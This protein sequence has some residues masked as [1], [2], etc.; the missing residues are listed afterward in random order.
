MKHV[1]EV[2]AD[3]LELFAR[4][5]DPELM[6]NLRTIA[7]DSYA[8]MPYGDAITVLQRSGKKFEFPVEYGV[9]LQTEHER[10]LTEEYCRKPVM[11]HDYPR[12]IK[13]FY[14]RLNDD[15]QTVAAMDLL[16]PPY[17]RAYR[18]ESEGRTPG[19]ART[20]PRRIRAAP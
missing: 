10:Y 1:L 14:M 20:A 17:R 2:C 15:G 3:D 13:S 11:V 5:V 8:R 12:E 16:V 4:F 18:R 19:G 9:D 7:E 6:A